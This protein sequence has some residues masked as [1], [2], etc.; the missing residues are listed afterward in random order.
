MPT[1]SLAI[2]AMRPLIQSFD[3]LGSGQKLRFEVKSDWL[4]R[5]LAYRQQQH[6]EGKPIS[7]PFYCVGTISYFDQNRIFD[8][9]SNRSETG[10]C[11]KLV[12]SGGRGECWISAESPEHEYA[13]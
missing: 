3:E 8:E 5:E 9:P 2:D 1:A 6:I 10:F 4:V 7:P 13:Y 11:F 12:L